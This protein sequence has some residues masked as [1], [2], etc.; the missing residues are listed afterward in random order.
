MISPPTIGQSGDGGNRS[1]EIA[2]LSG[3]IV[4]QLV[5][6]NEAAQISIPI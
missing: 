3:L 1:F 4:A 6:Q 5:V 2:A